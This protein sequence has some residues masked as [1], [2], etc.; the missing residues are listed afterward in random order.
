MTKRGASTKRTKTK[1]GAT[2]AYA[3]FMSRAYSMELEATERYTQFAERLEAHDND[4]V[5]ML[6][7]KLAEIEALHTKRILAEMGWS[8]LPVLPPAFAWEGSEGPE[9]APS[10][11][12]RHEMQPYHALEIAL[13]CELQAQKYFENIASGAA[14]V[15]AAA[16]EMATEE[17][18]HVKLI[19]DW[20][21]RVPRPV[22]GSG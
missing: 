9:T 21:S 13:R 10:G 17:G 4:E 1:P 19:R 18:E 12:L 5:A 7:R 16:E 11:S 15:R 8:S 20:L 22:S 2:D 6:F 3:A 14:H